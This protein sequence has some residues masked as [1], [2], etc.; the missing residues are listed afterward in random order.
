MHKYFLLGEEL[1]VSM[2]TRSQ[3]VRLLYGTH[4]LLTDFINEALIIFHNVQ[5]CNASV[6]F[7]NNEIA[8][9]A[10]E[11]KDRLSEVAIKF[12]LYLYES[13]LNKSDVKYLVK[14]FSIHKILKVLS[15]GIRIVLFIFHI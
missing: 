9:H 1:C 3:A 7:I 14:V 6:E 5:Y 15:D 13:N 12:F 4:C 2:Q 10:N 8:Q 11:S